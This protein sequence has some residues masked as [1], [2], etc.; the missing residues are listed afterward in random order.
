[1]KKL[2]N[3]CLYIKFSILIIICLAALMFIISVPASGPYVEPEP[4]PTNNIIEAI[5]EGIG[6]A[7]VKSVYVSMWRYFY[8][9]IPVFIYGVASIVV[10]VLSILKLEDG[11][12]K[13]GQKTLGILNLFIG[14]LIAGI[15]ILASKEEDWAAKEL[16]NA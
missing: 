12:N 10:I 5:L 9:S 2:A 11:K 14:S 8:I 1:M 7:G 3:V 13:K 4:E 16:A 6:R 15:I